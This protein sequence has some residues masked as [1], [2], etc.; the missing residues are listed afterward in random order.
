M[1]F[2][3]FL[4]LLEALPFTCEDEHAD[5]QRDW[6]TC[7]SHPASKWQKR[8]CDPRSAELQSLCSLSLHYAVIPYGLR[9]KHHTFVLG[10]QD[11]VLGT[12]QLWPWTKACNKLGFVLSVIQRRTGQIGVCGTPGA[13]A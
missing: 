2:L 8:D 9:G 11:L 13:Y 1:E 6:V 10:D 5:A 3:H 12:Y 4:P 7:P